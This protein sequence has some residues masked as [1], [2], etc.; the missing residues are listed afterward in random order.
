MDA[1][2]VKQLV[3]ERLQEA[4]QNKVYKDYGR[5]SGTAKERKALGFITVTITEEQE[6]SLD[7]LADLVKKDKILPKFDPEQERANGNTAGAAYFRY[8][9][10]RNWIPK[11]TVKARE[12]FTLYVQALTQWN[13]VTGKNTT[14]QTA[15]E[16]FVALFQCASWERDKNGIIANQA[17]DIKS[18]E[19]KD[20]S[21]YTDVNPGY[22]YKE[23]M[24]AAMLAIVG[25]Q[26]VKA[27]SWEG[28]DWYKEAKDFEALGRE[29][30]DAL[31]EK[32]IPRLQE[33]VDVWSQSIDAIANASTLE[34]LATAT[35]SDLMAKKYGKIEWRDE[36][37]KRVRAKTWTLENGRQ[38]LVDYWK[39]QAGHNM[40]TLQEA[41]KKYSPRDEN[42]SWTA[43]YFGRT[44]ERKAPAAGGITVN[45]YPNLE[46]L[47]RRNGLCVAKKLSTTELA[48]NW[49][50]KAVQYGN[51]LSDG[52][53]AR[54]TYWANASFM[55]LAD[56]VQLNIQQ[57]NKRMGL[58]LDLATR[59]RKGSAAT[60][61]PTYTVINLN[62]YG[63]DGSLAHEWAHA[64]DHWL[65]RR[66]N[67][68]GF[69]S[70][71][72]S[73]INDGAKASEKAVRDIM[74]F[75]FGHGYR[76]SIT[77][78]AS[79]R[80][81]YRLPAI[82]MGKSPAEF[83]AYLMAQ[84][85]R[86]T[87]GNRRTQEEIA[88]DVAKAYGVESITVQVDSQGSDQY[89]GSKAMNKPYWIEPCELF[90]RS[91]E[92]YVIYRMR[93]LDLQS[94][95]L[96][97]PRNWAARFGVYPS[98][99]DMDTLA[100][101]FNTFFVVLAAEEGMQLRK[102]ELP[103][104]RPAGQTFTN[105]PRE[106]YKEKV[107]MPSKGK[108]DETGDELA[109]EQKREAQNEPPAPEAKPQVAEVVV[110]PPAADAEPEPTPEPVTPEP[111]PA[112][113]PEKR[114]KLSKFGQQVQRVVDNM[115]AAIE[116]RLQNKPEDG[117]E[118]TYRW[119]IGTL[120][121]EPAYFHKLKRNVEAEHVL[122]YGPYKAH[123]HR[124]Y[125]GRGSD[126]PDYDTK[127]FNHYTIS[128]FG[129]TYG[130]EH[131]TGVYNT[132][133]RSST[134]EVM[135]WKVGDIQTR[136]PAKQLVEAIEKAR[137][138]YEANNAE[139]NA[140]VD[141]TV[142]V[143]LS[144]RQQKG[145]GYKVK[146]TVNLDDVKASLARMAEKQANPLPYAK[147]VAR[148]GELQAK[149]ADG[150]ITRDELDELKLHIYELYKEGAYRAE[151]R[152]RY[153]AGS[154]A[155]NPEFTTEQPE[156]TEEQRYDAELAKVHAA[157]W[158]ADEPAEQDE[159][160]LTDEQ[161][162]DV[163]HSDL[164]NYLFTGEQ[165]NSMDMPTGNSL[166]L[167]GQRVV[168][169][170]DAVDVKDERIIMARPGSTTGIAVFNELVKVDP[171]PTQ[172]WKGKDLPDVWY[173][174][175]TA[176]WVEGFFGN[177]WEV[178]ERT[179]WP[180]LRQAVAGVYAV[181]PG[182]LDAFAQELDE[183]AALPAEE[184]KARKRPDGKPPT[185]QQWRKVKSKL[186]GIARQAKADDMASLRETAMRIQALRG[187]YGMVD[188][189]S[190][191][192]RTRPLTKKTLL[193]WAKAPGRTDLEGIDTPK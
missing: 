181:A 28:G 172:D 95:Y 154:G 105:L 110:P 109:D 26:I 192:K 153:V 77:V 180:T 142:A 158:P 176:R 170:L 16:A 39:R 48:E 71:S 37:L 22:K 182:Q 108:A 69:L 86:H 140:E 57:L 20:W 75:T 179:S 17:A 135:E 193:S 185:P 82:D 65:G 30:A 168:L 84:W 186:R 36:V 173:L 55:D 14:L 100:P 190:R 166:P 165:T 129:I 10:L 116:K 15:R 85:S 184:I 1:S 41:M 63:G 59:G 115:N 138:E 160:S 143:K 102:D 12:V 66:R 91:F 42:W 44:V 171:Y 2:Q 78:K 5:I 120:A 130:I 136:M 104:V 52:E 139:Q 94:D 58:G 132:K 191:N 60:Y 157:Y 93:E 169:G 126:V 11:P 88:A 150:S 175:R 74:R 161:M 47:E 137:A 146:P 119:S 151:P 134:L 99:R 8:Q 189:A 117:L 97:E 27:V 45:S 33:N 113:K 32:Y 38:Q 9:V 54:L 114:P 121:K 101:L 72:I 62:R 49:G 122:N 34:E 177:R 159:W 183:V 90:A 79:D 167:V 4:Q 123:L 31:L 149:L 43:K 103:I 76:D 18:L 125:P 118:S 187:Y 156:Q 50:L 96:Q 21:R 70:D 147:L 112:P 107:V 24:K 145:K 163:Q 68:E 80:I 6:R 51:S 178:D 128:T 124:D 127:P 3:E 56:L 89:Q 87:A 131:I 188:E 73:S 81:R 40:A 162:Q 64:M 7:E 67:A 25:K 111:T 133:T 155:D 53:S 106:S 98:D 164:L 92:G 29:E 61:W 152:E 141:A 13:E 174:I 148:E 35:K 83:H 19:G 23:D 46:H 144:Q